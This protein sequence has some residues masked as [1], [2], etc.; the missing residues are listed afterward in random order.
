MINIRYHF[1]TI[2]SIFLAL[3]IGILL[4]GTTGQSWFTEK[5]RE[6]LVNMEKKYNQ[7]LKNNNELKQQV[8]RLIL[9]VE[10]NN[11]EVIHLMVARYAEDLHGEKLYVWQADSID[12]NGLKRIFDP[13]G[14]KLI[15]YH[16]EVD[17]KK[18]LD[19]PL[20]LIGTELPDWIHSFPSEQKWLHLKA[21]PDSPSKKWKLLE[22]VQTLLKEKRWEREKS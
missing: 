17:Q 10:R 15:P 16:P 20:L 9:E 8:N 1:I 7:A 19:S 22:S 3:G 4:G 18:T 12:T 13:I 2:A 21:L 6:F 11:E 5:E 14:I